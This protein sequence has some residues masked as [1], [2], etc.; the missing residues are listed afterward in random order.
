MRQVQN[1]AMKYY[2]KKFL[3]DVEIQP[4]NLMMGD[5]FILPSYVPSNYK[6]SLSVS[7]SSKF[8]RDNAQGEFHFYICLLKRNNENTSYY[9]SFSGYTL[10]T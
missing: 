3:S 4:I 5:E 2:A 1:V 8:F 9:Q 10:D 7:F 6:T